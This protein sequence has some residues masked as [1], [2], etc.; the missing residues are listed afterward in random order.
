MA[1]LQCGPTGAVGTL[2]QLITVNAPARRPEL[3]LS[4]AYFDAHKICWLYDMLG[5]PTEWAQ[6]GYVRPVLTLSYAGHY[7]MGQSEKLLRCVPT[8][9]SAMFFW[10]QAQTTS[11]V[12]K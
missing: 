4:I 3:K 2:F 5:R 9:F 10:L 1:F 6:K 11:Q 8:G 12:Q 7:S